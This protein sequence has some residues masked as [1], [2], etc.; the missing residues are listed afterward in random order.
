MRFS[1][2]D[3]VYATLGDFLEALAVSGGIGSALRE[4]QAS[5][6]FDISDPVAPFV[7]SATG[8]ISHG[9]P[10]GEPTCTLRGPAT[11]FDAIFSGRTS[12]HSE[13]S[14]RVVR[15][16]GNGSVPGLIWPL[17]AF[18]APGIYDSFREGL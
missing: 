2:A 14:K 11:A 18:A 16:E 5:I 1:S 15:L 6:F 13:I 4:T 12:I 8:G 7:L 17:I 9:P 3:H 10:E